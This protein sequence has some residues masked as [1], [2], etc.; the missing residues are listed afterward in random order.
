MGLQI[1]WF[2]FS[3]VGGFRHHDI[4]RHSRSARRPEKSVA[5]TSIKTLYD[6]FDS[7]DL[8]N[9]RFLPNLAAVFAPMQERPVISRLQDSHFFAR[10]QILPSSIRLEILK[11]MRLL[12]GQPPECISPATSSQDESP[13]VRST[14]GGGDNQANF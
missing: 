12:S 2:R 8:Q 4:E 3:H 1:V 10:I 9:Q 14:V 11:N 5:M 7:E 6:H 13:P